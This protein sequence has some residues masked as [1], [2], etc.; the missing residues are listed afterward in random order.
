VEAGK[1]SSN[2]MTSRQ[3]LQK[4]SPDVVYQEEEL[5]YKHD[6]IKNGFPFDMK[7]VLPTQK[8]FTIVK[9]GRNCLL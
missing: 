2:N 1:S 4:V 5:L 7:T 9:I 3:A 8:G 6:A